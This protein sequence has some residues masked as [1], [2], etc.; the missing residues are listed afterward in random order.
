MQ[1]FFTDNGYVQTDD[2]FYSKPERVMLEEVYASIQVYSIDK[3]KNDQEFYDQ[4]GTRLFIGVKPGQS[5]T[6]QIEH[7]RIW[8][9]LMDAF[10]NGI[11]YKMFEKLIEFYKENNLEIKFK[12]KYNVEV[13]LANGEIKSLSA[14]NFYSPPSENLQKITRGFFVG[15]TADLTISILSRKVKDGDECSDKI[16]VSVLEIQSLKEKKSDD[17]ID[18]KL[19]KG[20]KGLNDIIWQET[21]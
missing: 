20:M 12:D 8:T 7:N 19:F 11:T 13:T 18:I 1:K 4:I 9:Y 14:S 16:N 15:P 3:A 6:S 10:D 5:Y 21:L 17:K 2:N